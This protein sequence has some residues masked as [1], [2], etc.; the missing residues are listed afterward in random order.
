MSDKIRELALQA[1][2]PINQLTTEGVADGYIFD[3][4]WFQK[5]NQRFAELIIRDC[6]RCIQ[7]FAANEIPA[8]AT[9][10]Y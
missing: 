3:Q 7:D 9:Q 4:E 10:S 1:F 2:L 6:A 8:S 5:Y